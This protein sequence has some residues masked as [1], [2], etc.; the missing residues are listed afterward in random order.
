M[1]L[2]KMQKRAQSVD[3]TTKDNNG[4]RTSRRA[5]SADD[6]GSDRKKKTGIVKDVK[7]VF[8]KM[9]V[10]DEADVDSDSENSSV[11]RSTNS[12]IEKLN[13]V[14]DLSG[15]FD[16]NSDENNTEDTNRNS[17]VSNSATDN[18]KQESGCIIC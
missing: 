3:Q 11:C 5:Y 18:T 6:A 7:S 17:N 16:E 4:G 14:L 2:E 13:F 9:P 1:L 15:G 10:F 8:M 12:S